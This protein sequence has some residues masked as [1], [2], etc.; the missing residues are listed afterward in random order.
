MILLLSY[1]K[2]PIFDLPFLFP[3]LEHQLL[4]VFPKGEKESKLVSLD[5]V[6]F[7]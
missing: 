2:F 1:Y 7:G 3:P 5:K 6:L 4:P